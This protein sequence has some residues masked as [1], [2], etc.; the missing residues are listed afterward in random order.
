MQRSRN[1]AKESCV[2]ASVSV[3]D[4]KS[5][6]TVRVGTGLNL[7]TGGTV[8]L[9][10]L[11]HVTLVWRPTSA[12][13]TGSSHQLV[14]AGESVVRTAE[15]PCSKSEST[16]WCHEAAASFDVHLCEHGKTTKANTEKGVAARNCGVYELRHVNN[17]SHDAPSHTT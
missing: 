12:Q 4:R 15:N 3:A 17:T 13:E 2:A 10:S 16:L 8:C 1:A 5:L 7:W 11:H 14:A 6:V 9:E